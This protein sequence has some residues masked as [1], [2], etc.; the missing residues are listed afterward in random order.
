MRKAMAKLM[1]VFA[2][3]ENRV[4]AVSRRRTSMRGRVGGEGCMEGHKGNTIP[5]C[6]RVHLGNPPRQ[7]PRRRGKLGG[8]P[9]G[10]T[11]TQWV[12]G[13]LGSHE[14]LGLG[15][16]RKA[17][18][19]E[20]PVVRARRCA[21]VRGGDT[22]VHRAQ[23]ERNEGKRG[24]KWGCA[25]LVEGCDTFK[26]KPRHDTKDSFT[27]ERARRRDATVSTQGSTHDLDSKVG[28]HRTY[29]R[30][31]AHL[32]TKGPSCEGVGE[33][34]TTRCRLGAAE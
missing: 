22:T 26:N 18:A 1:S 30:C 24:N 6:P 27:Q 31:D 16:A 12:Q 9:P 19:P 29:G 25:C 15:R 7:R 3:V 13:G 14:R 4:C 2:V 5:S 28:R 21:R 20:Q 34:R 32:R 8:K 11:S 33:E 23:Q 10:E 17:Y